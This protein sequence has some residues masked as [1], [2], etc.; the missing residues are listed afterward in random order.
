MKS[1]PL[2][3][4]LLSALCLW[5]DCPKPDT[6]KATVI[7]ISRGAWQRLTR[8]SIA[9]GQP[10]VSPDPFSPRRR[11]TV[12]GKQSLTNGEWC[13]AGPESRFFK[14]KVSLP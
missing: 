13:V 11:Y 7:P 1:I 12:L 2:C 9:A 5:A 14:V 10:V 6:T 8:I 3:V 4:V